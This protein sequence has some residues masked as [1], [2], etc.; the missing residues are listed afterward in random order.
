MFIY[1]FT[2]IPSVTTR[3]LTV[4]CCGLNKAAMV[5]DMKIR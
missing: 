5:Y 4:T 1:L 2:Q 3:P